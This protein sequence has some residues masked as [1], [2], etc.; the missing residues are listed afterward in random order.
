MV[1]PSS[2]PTPVDAPSKTQS[3]LQAAPKVE[4][5]KGGGAVRGI[6]EK[7]QA[8]AA[9]GSAS[10]TVPLA[11]LPGRNGFTPAL[12][13]SYDSGAGNG[14][15][16]LGWSLPVG[17]IQRKT[18]KG[19]PHYR[20]DE[21]TF[22]LSGSEDLVPV[23]SARSA[24]E[25]SASYDVQR[26]QP[27]VESGYA[28]I[29]RWTDTTTRVSHWR[30]WTPQNVRRLYGDVSSARLTHP[31]VSRWVFAWYLTEERDELG[32]VV[33]Y[34]Y[35]GH[36]R[37][38]AFDSVAEDRRTPSH[39]YLKRV[40]W[41]NVAPGD[42]TAF[43]YEL[44]LD[45]GDHTASPPTP[46]PDTTCPARADVFSRHRARFD[47]RCYRL[48]RRALLFAR[49]PDG[50]DGDAVLVKA[51]ELA[52]DENAVATTL[53]SATHRGYAPDGSS[54]TLPALTFGYT[55][56]SRAS[57]PAYLT[58]VDDL[59]NGVDFRSAQWVDLDGEGLAGLL[60]EQ[61]GAW[62]YKRNEG[63]GRLAHARRLPSLPN[64]P[65]AGA[66]LVDV[67][68]DGRLEVVQRGGGLHGYHARARGSDAWEPFRAFRQVT[69]VDPNGPNVVT[70]DADG[71]GLPDLV[72]ALAR[73]LVTY[74]SEGRSGYGAPIEAALPTDEDRGPTLLFRNAEESVFLADMDG[75]GL[76]DVVRVRQ[77]NV[78]YWPNLGYGRF[79]PRV[80]MANAPWFDAHDRFDPKRVRLADVDGSGP[81]DLVYV[82]PDA[83]RY[84]PNR[85][86]N[87]F[88]AEVRVAGIPSV[89][90]TANVTLA[91]VRG[92]G[93]SCLVWSSSLRRD[94]FAPIRYLRLHEDGKPYLLAR[95]T[96][97]LGRTTSFSYTPSTAYYLAD[98]RAGAPW[99]TR[100][101][102]PVQCLSRVEVQDAA[103]G[104][105]TVTTYTYH[106]G[107]FDAT[108]REFRGFARV[109]Q[110]DAETL[111]DTGGGSS[112]GTFAQPPVLTRTWFHTG[113]WEGRT[114]LEAALEAE[115][116]TS[117]TTLPGPTTLPTG[118]AADRLREAHRAL[119]G[120]PLRVEVYAEDGSTSAGTP[121]VVTTSRYTV[122]SVASGTEH[123]VFRVDDRES[124]AEH[125]ERGAEARLAHTLVLA[126]N[127]YGTPERTA[128][129][130]YARASG[131]TEQTTP[132]VTLATTEHVHDTASDA[133]WHVNVQTRAQ[134]WHLGGVALS[135]LATVSTLNAAFA[136]ATALDWTDATP[137]SGAWRRLV[138]DQAISYVG[139]GGTET[140][141]SGSTW[142]LG[143]RA[144]V[145]QT[146]ARAFTAADLTDTDGF[147]G[148]VGT[149][150]LADAG[151]VT[152]GLTGSTGYWAPS[153]T[154]TRDASHFY[155]PTAV[156]D[157]FGNV[158]AIAWHASY[159][160]P[161]EVADALDNV[162]S[163][164]IDTHHGQV[165]K[166]TDPN[167]TW[168]EV[169]F[170]ALGRVTASRRCGAAGEG[171]PSATVT[172]PTVRYTYE[173]D[174]W[175]GA[176]PRPA[177]VKVEQRETHA[178]STT[179][180]LTRYTYSDGGG[181]V[182]QEKVQVAPDSATPTTPRWVGTGRVVLDN[183]GNAVK[184]YEP[185]FSA[186]EEFEW[187]DEFGGVA[188]TTT[189]D[190]VGRAIRVDLPNGTRRRVAFGPWSQTT[191]DENDCS[192]DA[193]LTADPALLA[194]AADH[195]G[196]PT[197]VHL[198][199]QGRSYKTEEQPDTSTTYTTRLTLDVV[200]NPV[201]VTDARG[202]AIQSQRFDQLGRPFV[203][204]SPDGGDVVALLDVAGQPP[205]LW[206]S[207][208]LGIE[209]EVDALRRKVRTWQ[210]DTSA[211]TKVLR[212]RFVYGEALYVPDDPG[213]P[214]VP[215][216][217]PAD[218][219]LR[220]RLYRVYSAACVDEF[221]YD[222]KGNVASTTRR[223]FDDE[224]A[225]V[226]WSTHDPVA[227]P[228]DPA[229][230]D[231]AD[232]VADLHT[233]ASA[234]LEDTSLAL[235]VA[236]TFDALD[237]V[238]ASTAPDGSVTT[239]AYDE[240]GRLVGVDVDGDDFVEGVEYNARGQRTA[241]AYGNGTS[242]AYTYEAE[243]FRLSTLVTTRASDG[244]VLQ[245]L[246]YT[247]D[248]VGNVVSILNEAEDT[249]Y[250]DNA[251]VEPDQE[252]EYDAL[253]RLTNAWGREKTARGRVDW[254]EPAYGD[255]PDANETMRAYEQRY[256][257]DEVGN[258]E[259]MRHLVGG[260][261]DWVRT[262]TYASGSNRLATTT[263]SAGTVGYQHDA[264]GSVVFLPHLYDDGASPS[265][266]PNVVPDFRDQMRRAE[267]NASDYALYAY[268]HAGQRARKIVK[269][270]SNVE[271]RRYVAGYEV[272]R[273]T[274]SGTL[275]AERTT[276]HV[277]DGERRIAMVETEATASTPVARVRYQ[278]DNHLGTA[279]LELDHVGAIVSYEEFH[280]YGSTAWWAGDSSI[281]VSLKR[282][283]YTGKERDEETGLY[284]HGARY[285][286][287]WLARWTSADPLGLGDGHNR[288]C[289]CRANP[290]A[291]ADPEGL[292]GEEPAEQPKSASIGFLWPL[293]FLPIGCSDPPEQTPER[294]PQDRTGSQQEA[295][296]PTVGQ[297]PEAVPQKPL[298]EE[299]KFRA[300]VG[301]FDP[302]KN[303]ELAQPIEYKRKDGTQVTISEVSG[304]DLNAL[305]G[306]VFGE[307]SG[308]FALPDAKQR[309][310]ERFAV[311]S[312]VLNR[313]GA[314][315]TGLADRPASVGAVANSGQ[316]NAVTTTGENK[317]FQAT[318]SYA[319][320]QS[321]SK[322]NPAAELQ[323]LKESFAAVTRLIAA[324]QGGGGEAPL[325][326]D[327]FRAGK[328]PMKEGYTLIGGTRFWNDPVI[329]RD[330]E[331][332]KRAK[333]K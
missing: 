71:D 190:P 34:E 274:V 307:A 52:Y 232:T 268:D 14:V 96:N 244:A 179:R 188:A 328:T 171:D 108:E 242:T 145:H 47:V 125:W 67:D 287:P 289:Y 9:T 160:W 154:Q 44:V 73:S 98:R 94:G 191:W 175:T 314:L 186:S 101:P 143:D 212:E 169:A 312:T 29:E 323:D 181:N 176:D 86:G 208:D 59:P 291:L 33:V 157:P 213:P 158:T 215:G 128:T 117:P 174:R 49:F 300:E 235:A 15:F 18:D 83:V 243:T 7:F 167:G 285:Y 156:T 251:A 182:V 187:D 91:D 216:Y 161:V 248:P 88:G 5:P 280:P 3:L 310:A 111:T 237:R 271:D 32:N 140:F 290:I 270:G 70:L 104:L 17:S 320:W 301:Y 286:A 74:P 183:K 276:L 99:A 120:K 318:Q 292:A 269:T 245:D 258:V 100:L 68:G 131:D 252:F 180:W 55:A 105:S 2:A 141:P 64:V 58:G 45:Y 199:A 90:D 200:G 211:S 224:E 277:L 11:V 295:Q 178:S 210:W 333:L 137:S 325:A 114:T 228:Y 10:A 273:K 40:K 241:I 264:R 263:E 332:W 214:P 6:G 265:P 46:T 321:F 62:W 317:K 139:S 92:D 24:T 134:S 177:R 192:T 146:Y 163:A 231:D 135:G 246:R 293:L 38:G 250:F 294:L 284:Y 122:V 110:R 150:R 78:Q 316:Y 281:D 4:V 61:G 196:T 76:T 185:F 282:Y 69:N 226:D 36:A 56:A 149:T 296:G 329:T 254:V 324:D 238:V 123:D 1:R 255:A 121:Y 165:R 66:Q 85:S 322:S 48:C 21:D 253:Y 222:W 116:W 249:L 41:G 155:V 313:V 51:T 170:D 239:N 30:T 259:E 82:G 13:L 298:T 221:A 168:T 84:W 127:D 257:Y 193:D 159:L 327:T 279:V 262:Y 240:G 267:I 37:D 319:A 20:D 107:Y 77:G 133:R 138:A 304:A 109:D 299:E 22:V 219:H 203:T 247:Y 189:F 112:P 223:F 230:P 147:D 331:E 330:Y 126:V 31:S 39:V 27:R 151:Y 118:L 198:D 266:T 204:L 75:D 202:N 261:T 205:F 275:D 23:G 81:A 142:G 28:R 172:D 95:V 153:G 309:A 130:A 233:A 278:L 57:A 65:L 234:E 119:K 283:R 197:T 229:V 43:F 106:H 60:T 225:D 26:Y 162:V 148:R 115:W 227:Y 63:E 124:L 54:Q 103:T 144:L 311:A 113:A 97:G 16:G 218:D 132:V 89:E 220:G 50:V 164:E 303:Y 194:R 217:D 136:T 80:Q 152:P 173:L 42:A 19:L 288:Y 35:D 25:G 206:K 166:V 184:R 53:T 272:W 87:G 201:V 236:S 79:G 305:A 12:S 256:A 315:G 209:T 129:V 306:L 102:F 93:T 207:G 302:A 72:A 195:A 297:V 260:T 8:N 308:S 326:Y